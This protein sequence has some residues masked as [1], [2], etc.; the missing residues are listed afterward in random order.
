MILADTV[1]PDPSSLAPATA[2]SGAAV[3]VRPVSHGPLGPPF[4]VD[5]TKKRR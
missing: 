2:V 3:R 5:P 1:Y 4:S